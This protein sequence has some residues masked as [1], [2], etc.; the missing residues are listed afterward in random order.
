ME[1]ETQEVNAKVSNN[2]K[3]M[4]AKKGL[5][6]Q[7]L[8]R[9][10][11]GDSM[12]KKLSHKLNS[13]SKGKAALSIRDMVMAVRALGCTLDDVFDGVELRGGV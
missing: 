9:V 8:S 2:I 12:P 3:G 11:Y 6:V 1:H 10:I 7:D 4:I 5:H 13:L